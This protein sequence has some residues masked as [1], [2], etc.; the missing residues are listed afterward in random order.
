MCS[1]LIQFTWN[2]NI[3]IQKPKNSI[4][5][6]NR[7]ELIRFRIYELYK[8]IKRIILFNFAVFSFRFSTH[9]HC[10][11]LQRNPRS[12]HEYFEGVLRWSISPIGNESWAWYE[13]CT[14]KLDGPKRFYTN[15]KQ[16]T[17]NLILNNRV[18]FNVSSSGSV[19]PYHRTHSV[20]LYIR[21]TRK[22]NWI[23]LKLYFTSFICSLANWLLYTRYLLHLCDPTTLNQN[24]FNRYN[25]KHLC[26]CTSLLPPSMLLLLDLNWIGL[27]DFVNRM[28]PDTLASV[29]LL[30]FFGNSFPT[31]MLHK[32]HIPFHPIQKNIYAHSSSSVNSCNSI[33][34]ELTAT[35]RQRPLWKSNARRKIMPK[36]QIRRSK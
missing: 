7:N 9:E 33:K 36:M 20:Q 24:P 3:Y 1:I 28:H 8:L 32:Q 13:S 14:G 19:I 4:Q 23:I 25:I 2:V 31:T 26:Y 16:I 34:Y 27:D 10:W 17:L 21:A 5:K 18:S 29:Y 35:V 22:T 12:A 15:P 11:C 30:T 6:I